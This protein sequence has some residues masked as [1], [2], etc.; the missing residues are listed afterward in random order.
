MKKRYI[1]PLISGS[2]RYTAIFQRDYRIARIVPC[3]SVSEDGPCGRGRRKLKNRGPGWCSAS[4][5]HQPLVDQTKTE[6]LRIF[7]SKQ[8]RLSR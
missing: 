7:I 6:A 1:A 3:D 8:F 5:P 2:L 4:S